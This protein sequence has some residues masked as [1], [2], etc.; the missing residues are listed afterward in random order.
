V[1]PGAVSASADDRAVT[2]Q[3]LVTRELTL[4]KTLDGSHLVARSLTGDERL[5]WQRGV[6]LLVQ[7]TENN[8]R[9][10]ELKDADRDVVLWSHIHAP[11][12]VS[13]IIDDESVALLEPG[14]QQS[15]LIVFTLADGREQYRAEL[16]LSKSSDPATLW[17]AIQRQRD[18]D[19][20][21]AGHPSKTQPGVRVIPFD[22]PNGVNSPFDGLICG[23]SRTDGALSWATPVEQAIFDRTQPA[24]L[25]VLLLAAREINQLRQARNPFGS[26]VRLLARIIDK[27]TGLERYGI[28][29]DAPNE[30]PRL[31][32]DP[33]NRRIIAN[34]HDWQLE[35]TFPEPKPMKL[36]AK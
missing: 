3:P 30:A 1:L 11:D 27:R 24:G 22:T 33:D 21:F 19:I 32:P 34:F 15:R 7:R 26:R 10:L 12:A 29:Q 14:D 2:I 18:R 5:L 13:N 35:L 4:L 20:V 16:P 31:E 8:Q 25:P 28:E 23:V 9:R 17:L 36:P 6:R